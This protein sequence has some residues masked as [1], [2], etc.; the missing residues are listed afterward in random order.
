MPHGLSPQSVNQ[1]D[2]AERKVEQRAR[3]WVSFP[4]HVLVP[5]EYFHLSFLYRESVV[6]IIQIWI[7]THTHQIFRRPSPKEH[8]QGF[9][10]CPCHSSS[11]SF[12]RRPQHDLLTFAMECPND[13][14][15]PESV[16]PS[17][18]STKLKMILRLESL[19]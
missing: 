15:V 6:N 7:D 17:C 3:H 8:S 10:V 5:S 2:L 18:P 13:V 14:T 4:Y 9:G 1:L 16:S 12:S 11:T 19:V